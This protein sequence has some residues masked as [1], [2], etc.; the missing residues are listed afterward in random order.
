MKRSLSAQI[1]FGMAQVSK[2][3]KKRPWR[4][5]AREAQQY[6]DASI[7][8]V[9]P[10]LPQLPENLPKN[11]TKIPGTVLYWEEIKITEMLPE[12]LLS[13]LASGELTAVAVTTAFLRRASLAQKLV[14]FQGVTGLLP[15]LSRSHRPTA[16]QRFFPS[17]P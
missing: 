10:E 16:L 4:D 12:D 2:T 8:R 5:I 3:K 11:V 7:A 9:Q 15:L 6:R 13:A 14:C 17:E 1:S